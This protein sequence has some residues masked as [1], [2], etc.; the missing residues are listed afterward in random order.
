MTKQKDGVMRALLKYC[1]FGPG[2]TTGAADDDPSG[3]ATYSQAGAQF[4]YSQLWTAVFMLPFL[5]A[6]QEVCGRIGVVTGK[7]I[8]TVIK[9]NYSKKILFFVVILVFIANIINLGADI[10]SMAAAANLIVPVNFYVLATLFSVGMVLAEIFIPYKTYAKILKWLCLS[11]LC[12]PISVFIVSQPWLTILKATF[13]PNIELNFQ[14]LFII[15]GVFGTTISPYLFFWQAEQEVEEEKAATKGKNT[16]VKKADKSAI[17]R[18]RVDN[19]VGMVFS[20]ITTWSIIVV[21]ATV[22][23]THGITDI[24]SAADAAKALE[25]LVQTFPHAGY[26]SKLIFAV[27][28]I[29]LGLLSVPILAGTAAYAFSAAFALPGGLDLKFM[30]AKGFYGIIILGMLLGY[31]MN[32][33]GINPMKALIYSA[34]INGIVA[35]PLIFIIALIGSN[36]KIMGK[37]RSGMGSKIFVWLTFIAMTMTAMVMFFTFGKH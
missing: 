13:V 12:Y 6:I 37:Y 10:G 35:V 26:L 21:A 36:K 24:N 9:E 25:P 15:T 31:L 3:I 18:M 7:G 32:F 19:L 29:G 1:K 20:E 28:I 5:I 33:M 34:V 22:L 27:G 30:Q 16:H 2:V 23:H 11:L 14:F 4:G 8:A 17:I